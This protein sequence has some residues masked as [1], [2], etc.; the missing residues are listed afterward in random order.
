MREKLY[1]T[2]EWKKIEKEI[3]K[4]DEGCKVCNTKEDLIVHHKNHYADGGSN[5]ES[6]LITLCNK[7]HGQV[8]TLERFYNNNHVFKTF[9]Q[10]LGEI[11]RRC[12][13]PPKNLSG[14]SV[15][16]DTKY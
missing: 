5:E 3:I 11:K 1:S 2:T 7:H 9:E 15:T 10:I 6:N 16:K 13:L 8:H 14:L 4:R 12:Q